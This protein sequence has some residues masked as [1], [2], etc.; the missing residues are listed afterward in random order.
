[1][2]LDTYCNLSHL[3]VSSEGGGFSGIVD[4][5]LASRGRERRVAAS[6]QS[7][8]LAPLVVSASDLLCTL[9]RR[10]LSR[11]STAL[12]LFD[13][14]FELLDYE[15]SAFWH[16]RRQDDPAHIWLRDRIAEASRAAVSS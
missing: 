3:I 8:A 11:F 13:P 4:E 10:L 16:P 15:L 5:L 12:D 6:V 9:P 2:D 1:M 7:Y 14:P